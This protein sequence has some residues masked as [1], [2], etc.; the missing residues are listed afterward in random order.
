MKLTKLLTLFIPAIAIGVVNAA[1]P[2]FVLY[3]D[4]HDRTIDSTLWYG[5]QTFEHRLDPLEGAH[6]P[7][8][9]LDLR[10]MIKRDPASGEK[11][12]KAAD[13]ELHL[14]N[15]LQGVVSEEVGGITA[16]RLGY[17]STARNI[18]GMGG[19]LSFQDFEVYTPDYCNGVSRSR[20]RLVKRFF[21]ALSAN[22]EP[23]NWT[24]EVMGYVGLRRMEGFPE[25][26][27]RV[28][29]RAFVCLD[30]ECLTSAVIPTYPNFG[31]IANDEIVEVSME[32][33]KDNDRFIVTSGATIKFIPYSLPYETEIAGGAP[34]AI[35][36]AIEVPVCDFE[37]AIGYID[38]FIDE[39]FVK[40]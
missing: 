13:G 29:A 16:S 6:T 39:V 2:G 4:F 11:P 22:S 31:T 18:I 32:W 19:V 23:G 1:P 14:T 27:M 25:G 40:Y 35:Q 3:D 10:R 37:P 7:W 21:N 8:N 34:F 5:N 20:L 30:P 17:A 15:T 33:D 12:G 9:S 28:E 24:G 38:A 26:E 36:A